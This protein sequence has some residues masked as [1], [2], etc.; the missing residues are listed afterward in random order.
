MR[1]AGITLRI[2][3]Q[4][5]YAITPRGFRLALLVWGKGKG[6]R[7]G[8]RLRASRSTVRNPAAAE[9]PTVPVISPQRQIDYVFLRSEW[10]WKALEVR[11]LD[12][13]PEASDHLPLL[14]VIEFWR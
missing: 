2:R 4:S 11:A 9:E 10:E 5:R 3:L 1:V 14:T 12:D 6:L 7:K 13:R 8:K